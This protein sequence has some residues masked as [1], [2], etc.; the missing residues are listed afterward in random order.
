M[1][2]PACPT[3]QSWRPFVRGLTFDGDRGGR[4]SRRCRRLFDRIIFIA[5]SQAG[6]VYASLS[7]CQ[8]R[9]AVMCIFIIPIAALFLGGPTVLAYNSAV[10]ETRTTTVKSSKSN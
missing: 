2:Y 7:R 1:R 8:R 10:S 6:K 3:A 9:G 4:N 5:A